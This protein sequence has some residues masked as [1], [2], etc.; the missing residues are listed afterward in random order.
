MITSEEGLTGREL[1]GWKLTALLGRVPRYAVYRAEGPAAATALVHVLPAHRS[2]NLPFRNRFLR[3]CRQATAITSPNVVRCLG[4][5]IGHGH[6]WFATQDGIGASLL[7]R[8]STGWRPN[9]D[10]LMSLAVQAWRGLAAIGMAGMTHRALHPGL[11]HL[12]EQGILRLAGLGLAPDSSGEEA[13]YAAVDPSQPVECLAP[14]QINAAPFDARGDLYA[15]ACAL[16]WIAGGQPPFIGETPAAIRQGH[17]QAETQPLRR[18]T[19]ECPAEFSVLLQGLLAKLPAARQPQSVLEVLQFCESLRQSGS[20]QG[21]TSRILRS[22]PVQTTVVPPPAPTAEAPTR[23]ATPAPRRTSLLIALAVL[24]AAVAV[25]L[26]RIPR[27]EEPRLSP[28]PSPT[29]AEAPPPSSDPPPAEPAPIAPDPP[30]SEAMP[31]VPVPGP[32]AADLA[33]PPSTEPVPGDQP[34]GNVP[35]P[36]VNEVRPAA[37][38]VPVLP[39]PTPAAQAVQALIDRGEH[40]GPVAVL[41][42]ALGEPDVVENGG[43]RLWYGDYL[44]HVDRDYVIGV[45]RQPAIPPPA[46][47]P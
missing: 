47:K 7:E 38:A 28:P 10:Q 15:M 27:T 2:E 6:A 29:M 45:S 43:N 20:L 46:T 30:P 42:A 37:A 44:F 32:E 40:L 18:L 31:P 23:V 26:W 34:A 1:G 35:P 21:S 13:I 9:S 33:D 36:P 39:S 16:Y 14:E 19:A 22:A 5:G 11:M 25:L 41:R 4:C 8:I 17:L 24:T 12:D 3:E